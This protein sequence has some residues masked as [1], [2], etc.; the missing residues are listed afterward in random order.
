MTTESGTQDARLAVCPS[1]HRAGEGLLSLKKTMH[2]EPNINK[3]LNLT[4][5]LHAMDQYESSE[6]KFFTH[7]STGARK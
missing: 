7:A 5:W 3:S 2:Y 1:N 4:T 6:P